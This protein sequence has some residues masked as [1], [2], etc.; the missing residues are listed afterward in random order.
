MCA[1]TCIIRLLMNFKRFRKVHRLAIHYIYRMKF[2]FLLLCFSWLPSVSAQ[3]PS[4]FNFADQAFEGMDIYSIIQDQSYNYWFATDQGIFMH[5]GYSY[6]KIECAEMFG[7]SVFSFVITSNGVIY[8]SNLN[9]QIFKIEGGKCSL[10]Y[11]LPDFGSDISLT[12]N[13][14]DELIICSSF[15]MYVFDANSKLKQRTHFNRGHLLGPPFLTKDNVLITHANANSVIIY[16]K[17]KISFE[18][19]RL[20]PT[21]TI[22]PDEQLQF[23]QGKNEILAVSSKSQKMFRYSPQNK[24]LKFL[25]SLRPVESTGG[26]RFY[27]ID[28]QVWMT[29]NISGVSRLL[30]T[31]PKF[32]VSFDLFP[33]YVLSYIYKDREGNLLLGT[34]DKGVLVIPDIRIRDVEKDLSA[35]S[36]VNL[37]SDENDNVYFGTRSGKMIKYN[38]TYSTLLSNANKTIEYIKPWPNTPYLVADNVGASLMD[39]TSGEI[40]SKVNGSLKDVEFYSDNSLFL[41]L[42]FGLLKY[43]YDA[44]SNALK[45]IK[46]YVNGRVYRLEKDPTCDALYVATSDGLKYLNSK[47]KLITVLH[48]NKPIN[49][50]D[51]TPWEDKVLVSTQKFGV[52]IFKR[53]KLVGSFVPKYNNVELTLSKMLVKDNRIYANTL[54]RFVILDTKGT[55][56]YLFNKSSGLSVNKIY[57][58]CLTKDELWI[59]HSKGVQRFKLSAIDVKVKVPK[60]MVRSIRVNGK[61]VHFTSKK[62]YFQSDERK[63]VFDLLAPTLKNRENVRYHYKLEGTN[64]AWSV[65]D[66]SDHIITYN[67]LAPGEY[68]FL[69]KAEN[70]GVFSPTKSYSF[71]ISAPF[72]QRWW[73]FAILVLLIVLTMGAFYRRSLQIQQRKANQI[74]EL[75]ASRLIAIQS[76]MNPH[77]IFNSLNAIQDLVLKGDIDNSYT[78]ITK[79]SNLVRRTLTYSDK[80]LVEIQQEIKLIELYMS[81]E[82]LRFKEDLVYTITLNDIEDILIPPMLI[83]PFIENALLHGLLHREGIKKLDI[84]FEMTDVLTCTITDNGIGRVKSQ[85]I[86]ARQRANHESFAINA[87]KKRFDILE[88][89]YK[90]TLGFVYN[91]LYQDGQATGTQVVLTIPFKQPF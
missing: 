21:S 31:S 51:I 89:H 65:S 54:S 68:R 35:Y 83:Q 90:G 41:G 36:I 49:A 86:K 18:K 16:H 11:T 28:D 62:G 72:Y 9:H 19:I 50:L 71:F 88:V 22:A 82:K 13:H 85:E 76:Q 42:N 23:M 47:D 78:F 91:D 46:T 60:L 34:F 26:L 55:I 1:V 2:V 63:F 81:L 84:V 77:F 30:S 80:D 52:L 56:L 69:V 79:F 6:K 7:V 75:N 32:Q 24:H 37:V 3:Q 4:Y 59:A 48:K 29:S 15:N 74:N 10:F 5:D 87:I 58:F 25:S 73:F 27:S 66:Y 64:D 14:D 8:C 70:N 38:G 44:R 40:Y 17:G 43:T 39:K 45:L 20:D 61:Q 33:D 57:D 67:A 12:V 53:G